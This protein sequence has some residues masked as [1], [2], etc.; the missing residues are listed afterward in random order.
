MVR[1]DGIHDDLPRICIRWITKL[2]YTGSLPTKDSLHSSL[3]NHQPDFL[4][5]MPKCKTPFNEIGRPVEIQS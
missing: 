3:N 4:D 5:R 2:Q 1:W